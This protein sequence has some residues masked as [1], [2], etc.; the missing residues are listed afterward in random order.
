M[1]RGRKTAGLVLEGVD[2]T[3]RKLR[4][5][6]FGTKAVTFFPFLIN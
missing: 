2:G 6:S 3:D 4:Q 1:P 5:P